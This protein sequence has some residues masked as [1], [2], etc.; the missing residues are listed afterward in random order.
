M[1]GRLIGENIRIMEQKKSNVAR[2]ERVLTVFVMLLTSAV[3]LFLLQQSVFLTTQDTRTIDTGTTKGFYTADTPWIHLVAFLLFAVG[4]WLWKRHPRTIGKTHRAAMLVIATFILA[5][6]AVLICSCR[7]EPAKDAAEVYNSAQKLLNGDLSPLEKNGYID[8]CPNQIGLLWYDMAFL[9]LFGE[10]ATVALQL[11][12]VVWLAVGI[13]LLARSAAALFENPGRKSDYILLYVIFLPMTLYVTFM[14][15]TLPGLACSA[16]QLRCLIRYQKTPA[17]RWCL[18]T[19]VFGMLAVLF[20]QNYLIFSIA[21][22]L[23]FFWEAIRRKKF[24]PL[25]AIAAML[26]LIPLG[27]SMAEK[28]LYLG[29]KITP[30]GGKPTSSWIALGMQDIDAAEGWIGQQEAYRVVRL[31]TDQGKEVADEYCRDSIKDRLVEF[32]SDP[33]MALRF[34]ARKTTSQWNMP[35]FESI[36]ANHNRIMQP[37]GCIWIRSLLS[38]DG[39]LHQ[40]YLIVSNI[41]LTQIWI[42]SLI[43]LILCRRRIKPEQLFFVIVFLGGFFFHLF[44]EAKA[45]YTVVYVFLLLPFAA[46]GLAEFGEWAAGTSSQSRAALLQDGSVLYCGAVAAL[47]VAS[48]ISGKYLSCSRAEAQQQLQAY[49]EWRA[50]QVPVLESGIYTI[51]LADTD[52]YLTLDVTAE[53]SRA[54]LTAGQAQNIT[55]RTLYNMLLL[56]SVPQNQAYQFLADEQKKIGL[57]MSSYEGINFVGQKAP[58]NPNNWPQQWYLRPV[59]DGSSVL[60]IRTVDGTALILTGNVTTGEVLLQNQAD[61]SGQHWIAERVE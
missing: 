35:T 17:F 9:A 30:G 48:G 44:W 18:L 29:T 60:E 51:R 42:W 14:Y 3:L 24:Q 47:L 11:A 22:G 55:V 23:Y 43:Y 4:A 54:V 2:I 49:E 34:Y 56:D 19:G 27:T 10:H 40:L 16:A 37:Q 45:Q 21:V 6:L 57:G 32:M 61:V 41:V 13:E 8:L 12:N 52:L 26:L 38:V 46:Q 39:I 7:M 20:K 33:G 53:G 28:A 50:G 15:G 36:E 59:G 58:S 5:L 25:A 1:R 31:Y